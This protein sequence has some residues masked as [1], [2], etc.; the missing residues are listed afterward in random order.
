MSRAPDGLAFKVTK[1]APQVIL[2]LAADAEQIT[3]AVEQAV[4]GFAARGFRALGVARAE[5]D[6]PWRFL[7]VLPLF[8]P[9]REQAKA[10]IA[11]ARTMGVSVKMVT[12]DALAI[13]R[14]TAGQ[15]GLG[16]N[17][18]DAGGFGDTKHHETRAA[19]RVHRAGG[20]LRPGLPR[21]Q[22]PHRR[23]AATA[24]PYRR[25]D[26][27]RGERRARAEEGRLRHRRVGR[28]RRGARGGGHR[29]DDAGPVGDHRRR[30]RKAGRSSS[31]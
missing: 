2:A 27:R 6:G 20:R 24:R 18:L 7:G 12:G 22:V 11:T 1:G 30:S 14:E 28:D 3:P 8:D 10:T 26:R 25:H 19:G 29:A 4:N 13:A 17:I 21:A 9:P 31:G 15:L 23:R 5:G 16:T